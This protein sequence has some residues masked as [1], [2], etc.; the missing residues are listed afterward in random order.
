MKFILGATWK[1]FGIAGT[2]YCGPGYANGEFGVKADP[3]GRTTGPVDDLCKE[4]D[5]AYDRAEESSTPAAD[6]LVADLKLMAD[7]DALVDS[8][9]LSV[10]DL[11][12]ATAVVAAFDAKTNAYGVPSAVVEAADELLEKLFDALGTDSLSLGFG[13]IVPGFSIPRNQRIGDTFTAATVA[14]PRRDPLVLDLDGDGIETVGVNPTTP[15]LFDIV[16][17]GI[18]QSVGWVKAD[19]GFL[20]LDRN[21]NGS[22]DSGA[23]LFGDATVLA[24][25]QK[26][27]DGFAALAERDSNH[28]GKVD[29]ADASFA[30]LRVWRDANQDGVSQASELA[31]LASLGIAALNVGDTSHSTVLANGNRIADIGSYVK[32]GG[33]LGG[34][35]E[36]AQS[37]DVDLAVD[38]FHSQFADPLDTGSVANLPD[39]QGAGQVRSLREAATLNSTLAALLSQFAAT[40]D[41]ATQQGM[42]DGILREWSNTSPM[43]ATFTGAY[44]GH[45]LTVNI[46]NTV[47]GSGAYQSW[48]DRLT[49]LEHFNGRTFNPVPSGSTAATVNLWTTTQA[50]LQQSYDQLKTS[51]YQ[52]LAL[53]T[54]LK[55][56]LDEIALTVS[57]TGVKLDFSVLRADFDGKFATDQAGAL[58]DLVDFSLGTRQ[59]LKDS[60]WDSSSEI[61]RYL[62]QV[63]ITPAIQASL[64]S[65]G[66]LVD[67]AANW[68]AGGTGAD[69]LMVGHGGNETFS[70]GDGQ[71]TLY[72]GAGD[73]N[74]SSGNGN[75]TFLYQKRYRKLISCVLACARRAKGQVV[76]LALGMAVL[77]YGCGGYGYVNG[78]KIAEIIKEDLVRLGYCSSSS[79][80]SKKRIV[81]Y[82]EWIN[83]LDVYI[84]A[85]VNLDEISSIVAS[86]I[87]KAEPGKVNMQFSSVSKTPQVIITIDKRAK[88]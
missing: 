44:A 32:T 17:T 49:I 61:T 75:D 30:S 55:P 39:M 33:Q 23:E 70:G 42:I 63:S 12:V 19:D 7:L 52:S 72:G 27:V 24:N 31:T 43:A 45:P 78:Q 87:T 66:L 88:Q 51:V 40:P 13:G 74:L 14:A 16:G 4:H 6:R 38:T 50:L 56:Y 62:D 15:L 9:T 1:Q 18:K 64:V 82:G 41:R 59:M 54:R 37:A 83:S 65:A 3:R 67:G 71:D 79:D 29:A 60:G 73:D 10:Q 5:L 53:Q 80:C 34:L 26:A 77:G 81:E 68:N 46:Q 25:G 48:A 57:E 35:G 69:D 47:T 58:A 21:G 76:C 85:N 20:V 11:A 22:I 28:D 86:V 8:G 2:N 84:Y 36:T